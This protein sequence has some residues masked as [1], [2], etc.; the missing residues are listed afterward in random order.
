MTPMSLR[1]ERDHYVTTLWLDRPQKHNPID[2]ATWDALASAVA[3]CSGDHTLR[4]VVIRGAGGRAFSAGADIAEFEATRGSP[5]AA[6]AYGA[7]INAC[8]AAL[9][10]CRHPV[11][12][13]IEGLCVGGGLEI[14]THCDLRYANASSR[15]GVP[16]KRLGLSVDVPE[17]AAL[18][19]LVGQSTAL[20]LL[21]EGRIM[22]S[23][24]ALAKGLVNRVSP[25]E[26]FEA[27]LQGALARICEGAPLV[28]RLHKRM[29]R[30]LAAEARLTPA[31]R[32]E[33]FALF[34]TQDYRAGYQA[35]LAKTD[36]VFTGG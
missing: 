26:A 11:I 28:A 9:L 29:A 25:D 23:D 6:R 8:M 30:R 19:R 3:T 35:F 10:A 7:R 4:A 16:V 12:A 33:P 14:A 5:E 13:A 2:A 17:M 1:T 27:D 21:L 24:E 18:L 22:P 34:G 15:F 32:D 36:P 31:E 20:E